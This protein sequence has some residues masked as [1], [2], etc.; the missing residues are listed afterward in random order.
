MLVG[1]GA[2]VLRAL[3][4]RFWVNE[5]GVAMQR[6]TAL[7]LV[8]WIGYIAARIGSFFLFRDASGTSDLLLSVGSSLLVQALVSYLRG[9]ALTGA[10][11][12][13]I[14]PGSYR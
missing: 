9:Q 5:G 3:T 11:T 10:R 2:G 14:T 12:P 1:V 7:T 8:V 13:S 4:M 6:G